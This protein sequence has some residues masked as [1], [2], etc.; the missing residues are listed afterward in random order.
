MSDPK[1][2]K[3]ELRHIVLNQMDVRV[4]PSLEPEKLHDFLQYRVRSVR[5]SPTNRM[6]DTLIDFIQKNRSRLSLPCSGNCY[7][8][9]DGVVL[10]C[11]RQLLEEENGKA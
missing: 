5:E 2:G 6:R 4:D 11:Y 10:F 3:E 7:E 8:H 9:H 1:T